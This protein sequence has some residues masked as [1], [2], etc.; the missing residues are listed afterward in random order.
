MVV[1]LM[2]KILAIVSSVL[3]MA[4]LSSVAVAAVIGYRQG[5]FE[6]SGISDP[7]R[8]KFTNV[9]EV[10]DVLEGDP[11]GPVRDL[12]TTDRG[13]LVVFDDAIAHFDTGSVREMWSRFDFGG[14]IAA[15]VTADG[16]RVVLAHEGAGLFSGQTRWMVLESRTGESVAAH[17]SKESPADLVS[18]LAADSRIEFSDNGRMTAYSLDEGRALW[19]YGGPGEGCADSAVE[20]VGMR[21]ALV[22][23]CGDQVKLVELSAESGRLWDSRSWS[24]TEAPELLPL[25][26]RTVPGSNTDPVEI[27][28]NG[29]WADGYVQNAE[30]AHIDRDTSSLGYFP[31][32]AEPDQLPAHILL[33]EDAEDAGNRFA[34]ASAELFLEEGVVS[35]GE[36]GDTVSLIDGKLP[37]STQEWD[38]GEI[39]QS[40]DL[41]ALLNDVLRRDPAVWDDFR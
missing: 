39:I 23:V 21:V 27:L 28:V 41:R 22:S 32:Q 30:G 4:L 18:V 24:G 9:A 1:L 2:Q 11:R 31:P 26:P 34:L 7:G 13:V 8:L 16:E 20:A 3:F 14:S 6:T 5:D 12:V 33:V 15:G 36:V 29:D 10:V 40:G 35:L 37:G 17:W 38:T 25:T 19:T